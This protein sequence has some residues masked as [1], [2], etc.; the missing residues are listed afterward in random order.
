Q[1]VPLAHSSTGSIIQR[2]GTRHWA[3]KA[4][5]CSRQPPDGEKLAL[6]FSRASPDKG[7][8]SAGVGRQHVMVP[9]DLAAEVPII[10]NRQVLQV[11]R[12]YGSFLRQHVQEQ[13]PARYVA[14]VLHVPARANVS[15]KLGEPRANIPAGTLA[16]ADEHLHLG[17]L[18]ILQVQR[19][20]L[21]V[22]SASAVERGPE[23]ACP[24]VPEL[25]AHA[26]YDLAVEIAHTVHESPDSV[27]T[28]KERVFVQ[29]VEQQGRRNVAPQ[30]VCQGV[31]KQLG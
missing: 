3:T 22:V 19:L 30:N 18:P 29:S 9:G 15:G 11:I 6:H 25:F 24:L 10:E 4:R 27:R 21:D 8:S 1:N 14:V 12:I 7:A 26:Q 31:P 20:P 16:V 2:G 13:R 28:V 23:I 17:L 5:S